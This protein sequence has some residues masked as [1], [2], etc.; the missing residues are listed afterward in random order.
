MDFKAGYSVIDVS[1]AEDMQRFLDDAEKFG[2]G[3]IDIMVNNAGV[4]ETAPF[5]DTTVDEIKTLF[6]VNIIGV[7]NALQCAIKK[8]IPNKSGK[9]V[10]TTSFA[11]QRGLDTWGHYCASK[12][13]A[14]SLMQSGAAVAAPYHINVNSVA[15]GII[16]TDMWESKLDGWAPEGPGKDKAKDEAFANSIKT[17]IPLNRPQTEQDIVDTVLFLCSDLSKEITGQT[18]NVDGGAVVH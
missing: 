1:K 2:N 6:D 7:N 11:G 16:R 18:I 4:L 9:I 12:A 17:F 13:A 5:L 10:I 15:P 14:I 3:K 8:M